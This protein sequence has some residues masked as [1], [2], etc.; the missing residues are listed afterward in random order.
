MP[1][2][3]YAIKLT[4]NTVDEINLFARRY[5]HY[6]TDELFGILRLCKIEHTTIYVGMVWDL[7]TST[8]EEF[9]TFNGSIF[10][11]CWR[12]GDG[13]R[14]PFRRICKNR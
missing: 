11:A 14:G 9:N 13:M 7:T 1:Y 6:M 5:D 3:E 2:V 4:E 10:D 12:Y 8:P